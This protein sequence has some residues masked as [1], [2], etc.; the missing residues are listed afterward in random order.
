MFDPQ[1]LNQLGSGDRIGEEAERRLDWWLTVYASNIFRDGC[2]FLPDFISK[3]A[4]VLTYLGR[5]H[6]GLG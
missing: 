2:I 6:D 1:N 3:S 5:Y 4:L